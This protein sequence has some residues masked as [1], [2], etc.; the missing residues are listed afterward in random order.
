MDS[1]CGALSPAE[2]GLEALVAHSPEAVVVAR[3]DSGHI[4][5]W[6]AVAESLFG[7]PAA[8]VI[9][10]PL[11]ALLPISRADWQAPPGPGVRTEAAFHARGGGGERR[12][13]ITLSA[14]QAGPTSEA[15]VLALAR[16]VTERLQLRR[17]GAVVLRLLRRLA[18]DASHQRVLD[19]LLEEAAAIVGAEGATVYGW[20]EAVGRLTVVR[21]TVRTTGQHLP[22]GQ[23]AV[24]Q[25][26]VRLGPVIVNDY[27]R[28]PGMV[29]STVAAGVEAAL[30]VPLLHEGRLLGALGVVTYTH[31]RNFGAHEAELLELL[32]SVAAAVLVGLER[33]RLE[34]ALLAAR[35]MAHELGNTLAALVV[36]VQLLE[37]DRRF[38]P[39]LTERAEMVVQKAHEASAKLRRLQELQTLRETSWGPGHTTIHI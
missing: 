32:A 33:A 3:A 2:L 11:D 19:D 31:G 18:A 37:R 30:A 9:G 15:Y 17:E 23:G 35:T 34:G 13:E 29:P 7:V 39:D 24:G 8:E 1:L 25:A 20:D 12:V 22:T 6:S 36:Q 14:I 26:I 10:Q 27:Q 5:L 21:N 28:A 4:V 16:E 38:P